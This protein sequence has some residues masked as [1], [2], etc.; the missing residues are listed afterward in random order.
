MARGDGRER[1]EEIGIIWRP[2]APPRQGRRAKRRL[3]LGKPPVMPL[4]PR[5]DEIRRT[6]LQPAYRRLEVK[7]RIDGT[8]H[9]QLRDLTLEADCA[10]ERLK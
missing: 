9:D 3:G 6:A 4:A 5:I 2:H 7:R 10:L 1:L 8:A